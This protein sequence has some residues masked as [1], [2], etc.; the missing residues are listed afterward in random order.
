MFWL[1]DSLEESWNVY[2]S[3]L[4]SEIERLNLLINQNNTDS[5][6]HFL[7]LMCIDDRVLLLLVCIINLFIVSIYNLIFLL[8]EDIF[9]C[10][11]IQWVIMFFSFFPSFY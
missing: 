3:N 8:L 7:L 1:P 11:F 10:I 6:V 4:H 2:K 9:C 5:Y